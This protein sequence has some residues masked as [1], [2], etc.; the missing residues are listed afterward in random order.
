MLENKIEKKSI[1]KRRKKN[2]KS[3]E[4]TYQNYNPDHKTG[5]IS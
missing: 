1:K 3:I 4:L 5:I 2:Y